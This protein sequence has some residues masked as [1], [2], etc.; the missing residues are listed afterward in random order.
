MR[1]LNLAALSKKSCSAFGWVGGSSHC[2]VVLLTDWCCADKSELGFPAHRTCFPAAHRVTR[3]IPT[4][5]SAGSTTRCRSSPCSTCEGCCERRSCLSFFFLY[6]RGE[7]QATSLGPGVT[8]VAVFLGGVPSLVGAVSVRVSTLVFF[9][10]KVQRG[11]T[12]VSPLIVQ[13]G[14]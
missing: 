2:K 8:W 4:F 10:P 9:P 13:D 1:C 3:Y 6:W 7:A 5:V 14:L 11:G 12:S